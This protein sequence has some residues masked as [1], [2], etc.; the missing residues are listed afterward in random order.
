MMWNMIGAVVSFAQAKSES[1]QSN[2]ESES[3]LQSIHDVKH[4]VKH[5]CYLVVDNRHQNSS[6]VI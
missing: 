1:I 4:G 6:L 5:V 3:M 2:S